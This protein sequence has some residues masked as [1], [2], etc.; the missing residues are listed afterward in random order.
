[1]DIISPYIPT[2]VGLIISSSFLGIAVI[3]VVVI[4]LVRVRHYKKA[5]GVKKEDI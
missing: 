2:N 3:T 4:L 1:M 5:L